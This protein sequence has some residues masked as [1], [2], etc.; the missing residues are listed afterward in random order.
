M[1]TKV[2]KSLATKGKN[3]GE[4]TGYSLTISNMSQIELYLL[5][6]S[7]TDKYSLLHN[8]IDNEF[9]G[10]IIITNQVTVDN[11]GCIVYTFD[12][13]LFSDPKSVKKYVDIFLNCLKE[14]IK[15]FKNKLDK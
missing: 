14:I 2:E 4:Q 13:F 8:E 9:S 6:Q 10:D 15:D 3:I 5:T 11:N 7:W 12:F 1:Q